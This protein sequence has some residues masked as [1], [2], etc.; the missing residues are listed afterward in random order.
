MRLADRDCIAHIIGPRWVFAVLMAAV[1]T[2]IVA[3]Y[4]L[5]GLRPHGYIGDETEALLTWLGWTAVGGLLLA[6]LVR[7]SWFGPS[8]MRRARSM[9]AS[10]H[11]I[12]AGGNDRLDDPMQ[13][14]ADSRAE[15]GL[16]M[17][18]AG[19]GY[20]CGAIRTDDD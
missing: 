5:S 1:W 15:C 16:R 8:P 10:K 19:F 4:V 2:A 14:R 13:W 11:T 20:Y 6:W 7:K 17:G 18:V 9:G 12:P 3:L